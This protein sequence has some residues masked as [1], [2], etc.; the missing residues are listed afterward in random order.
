[1]TIL[2]IVIMPLVAA[3]GHELRG[4][5]EGWAEVEKFLLL[6]GAIMVSL[7]S[8]IYFW[9]LWGSYGDVFDKVGVYITYTALTG[10]GIGAHSA[11]T[12]ARRYVAVACFLS[13]AVPTMSNMRVSAK[14]PL[15]RNK[16]NYINQNVY[17][18]LVQ[19]FFALFY[20]AAAFVD[21]ERIARILYWVPL[22]AHLVSFYPVAAFYRFL[23]RNRQ[24]AT[25][26]A[27]CWRGDCHFCIY[28]LLVL[29]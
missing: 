27:V 10:I 21:S 4:S 19:M 2:L 14:D 1:M 6:F 7:R 5:F 18:C 29:A 3:I 16:N 24:G 23:H 26:I 9:N 13:S 15:M 8:L 28:R 17:T 12:D 25:R 11:F 20:L 22:V